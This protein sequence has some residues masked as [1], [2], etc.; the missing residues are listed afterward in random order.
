M[1]NVM[2][3]PRL[4]LLA[5]IQ[6]L[7]GSKMVFRGGPYAEAVAAWFSGYSDYPVIQRLKDMEECGYVYDLPVSS[8][9]LFEDFSLTNKRLNW[10]PTSEEMNRQRLT[11]VE[12]VGSLEEFYALVHQF[13][14]QSDFAGFFASQKDYLQQR[15]DDTVHALDKHPDMIAHMVDWYGYS[16]SSYNLVISPLVRGGYGP[17]LADAEGGIHAYCVVSID[18][19]QFSDDDLKQLSSWF[20]HEFSHSYVNPLVDKHWD[21]FKSGEELYNVIQKKMYAAYNSWW[22]VVAEHLVRVNDHRL[23]ELY[24]DSEEGTTLQGEIDSGFLFIQAAYDAIRQYELEHQQHGT[25]YADYFPTIA[26]YFMDRTDISEEELKSLQGFTG[27]INKAFIDDLLI[28]YPDSER[29]SGVSKYIMPTVNWMVSNKGFEAVSDKKALSM[30]LSER[31]L[32]LFGAWGTNLILERFRENMPFEIHPD[33]ILADK[34]Y[35]GTDL[36]I[37]LCLP[38]PLNSKLGMC[39]YTAQSTEAMQGSNAIFHGPEDWYV[40][41]T[42]LEVLGS[43]NFTHKDERW[44]FGE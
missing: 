29:V 28:I 18:C 17:A 8:F 27:P 3:D 38:N 32:C 22:V 12:Q 7:S 25:S 35:T 13:A 42:K 19:S 23:S 34:T 9:L 36:R 31:N 4:E 44:R 16:L 15:V 24:F 20:F 5:V 40:S 33:S 2:V 39:I 10:D 30:D 21:L 14:M 43:G 11:C 26:K 1:L 37:A 41:N 6:Y